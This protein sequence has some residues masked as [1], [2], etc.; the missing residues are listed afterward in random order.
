LEPGV[1]EITKLLRA[2][3]GGEREALD[4]LIPRIYS[5]LRRLAQRHARR[6][7]TEQSMQ[8]TALVNEMY[9][10]LVDVHGVDWKD[11]AHF[12]AVCS[13]VMRR[14]LVDAARTRAAAKRGGKQASEGATVDFNAVP[15][16]SSKRDRE[17][18]ALDDALDELGKFDRRKLQVV[19]MRFFGGMS[20]EET[21][22]ILG[23]SE[24]TVL[25]DWRLSK[26]WLHCEM[27]KSTH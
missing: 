14:I 18:I 23:I 26:A 5:E 6:E 22:E 20:A 12:F 1:H 21:A 4:Q 13:Q 8:A 17:L 9:L 2:W 10:R 19:E 24:Q 11:R 27:A 3:A 15:D 7:R 25:R 16:L